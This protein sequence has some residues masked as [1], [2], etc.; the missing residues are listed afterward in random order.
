MDWWR[1]VCCAAAGYLL[2]SCNGAIVVSHTCMHDDIRKKAAETLSLTN[3]LR[4]FGGWATLLVVLMDMG[5]VVLACL[6]GRWLLP[7]NPQLGMMI[8][9]AMTELGHIFPVFTASAAAR[10][11]CRALH[12]RS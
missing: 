6:L 10:A 1:I 12:W 8:A 4:N 5:K 2:G 3:F 11:S 7:G 9:G